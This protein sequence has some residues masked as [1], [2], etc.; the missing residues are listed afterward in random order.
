MAN[1]VRTLSRPVGSSP[2]A[3]GCI[4]IVEVATRDGFQSVEPLIGTVSKVDIGKKLLASGITRLEAGS[5]VSPRA[6]PQLADTPEV[7][8]QIACASADS[9]LSALVATASGGLRALNHGV[10][11]LVFVVSVSE[12]HNHSNVRRSVQQSLDELGDLTTQAQVPFVLR[13]NLATSFDCPFEGRIAESSVLGLIEKCLGLG[14]EMEV[15][16]CDTT[17]K[18]LPLQVRSLS[19]S[20][21]E[22]LAG[23]QSEVAFHGHDTYGFGVANALMAVEAGVS[24][25]DGSTAGLGGCPFAPGASGNTATE[26]LVYMLHGC[27]FNTGVNLEKL[28]NVADQVADLDGA[29]TGGHLRDVPRE[30]LLEKMP[31][32]DSDVNGGARV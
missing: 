14:G 12:S 9:R 7:I 16:L 24:V 15:G 2:A 28:L 29:A 32:R 27:G 19:A 6:V 30:R 10:K 22:L 17:G 31:A 13:L 26:D 25:L 21:L 18:A 4:E 8:E 1:Q 5:F 3:S 20:V 11:E 23:S